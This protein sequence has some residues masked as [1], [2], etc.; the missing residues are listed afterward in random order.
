MNGQ[1]NVKLRLFNAFTE[2][3][4]RFIDSQRGYLARLNAGEVNVWHVDSAIVA[5]NYARKATR[6]AYMKHIEEHG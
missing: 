4:N 3:L 2:S 1:C 5:A 6:D